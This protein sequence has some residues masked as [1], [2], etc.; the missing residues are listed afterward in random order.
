MPGPLPK[1]ASQRR[2]ANKPKSYGA[3]EPTVIEAIKPEAQPELGFDAHPLVEELWS[4]LAISG[5][6]QLYSAA[7]WQR[8]R[9]ELFYGNRLVS[10]AR[11][12]GA[13]A[14][15][16]FQAGLTALLISPAEKRRLGIDARPPAR[17]VDEEAAVLLL[18]KYKAE[19]T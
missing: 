8:A 2:R 12:P 15:A 5:E 9:L 11:S 7:D 10:G 17:D 16:T 3:S 6:A 19:L 1:R 18:S 14:W 4:S 13:Q